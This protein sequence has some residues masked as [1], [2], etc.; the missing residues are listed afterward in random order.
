MPDCADMGD[1]CQDGT[2]FAGL[3][4]VTNERLFIPPTDQEKPGS[5]GTYMMQW[6]NAQGTDDITPDSDSD[7]RANHAHR[8]GNIADFEAFRACEDLVFGTHSDW[9]LPAKDELAQIMLNKGAIQAKGHIT[10]FQSTYWSSTEAGANN[11]SWAVFSSNGTSQFFV[12][13]TPAIFVR[14]VRGPH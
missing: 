12:K 13:D 9:Y 6:K 4:P 2:V 1:L 14:C 5:P 11:F 7:G 8:S 10:N 3:H